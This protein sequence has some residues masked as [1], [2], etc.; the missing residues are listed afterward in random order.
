[1]L[2]TPELLQQ[3]KSTAF[4]SYLE[5]LQFPPWMAQNP[6]Q[7]AQP[8]TNVKENGQF[9]PSPQMSEQVQ[10]VMAKF[11]QQEQM[12]FEMANQQMVKKN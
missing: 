12:K 11:R 1:M 7:N 6:T 5:Q 3:A 10:N 2:S 8:P 4:Q 9:P